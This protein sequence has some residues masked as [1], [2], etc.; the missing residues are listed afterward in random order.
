MIE[1]FKSVPGPVWLGLGAL[2]LVLLSAIMDDGEE[3]DD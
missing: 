1:L 2:L 3:I